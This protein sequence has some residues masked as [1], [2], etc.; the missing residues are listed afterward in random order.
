MT[1]ET[2]ETNILPLQNRMFRYAMSRVFDNQMARDIV[3]D[4]LV[5]LWN[6]RDDL[7]KVKNLEAW[8]I[9]ITRNTTV[10]KLRAKDFQNLPLD[11]F[12]KVGLNYLPENGTI[13]RDLIS[14]VQNLIEKLPAT[15]KEIF[16]LREIMGYSNK[17]IEELMLLNES[18]VKVNLFRARKKIR[19]ELNDLINYGISS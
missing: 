17:E 10:D 2:F 3:Q 13:T 5:K 12:E 14:K 1:R 7:D 4:S 18:Q 9:R 11:D 19:K 16:R 8:C 15:Q 6:Q